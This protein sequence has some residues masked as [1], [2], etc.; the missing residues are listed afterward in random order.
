[1]STKKKTYQKI[2]ITSPH[3]PYAVVYKPSKG[4]GYDGTGYR[5]GDIIRGGMLIAS[6]SCNDWRG[7]K[8]V[9]LRREKKSR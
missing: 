5:V 6:K 7:W 1:M 3:D 9:Y 8:A 2:G 4:G